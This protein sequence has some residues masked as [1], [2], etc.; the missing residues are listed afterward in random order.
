[1][2]NSVRLHALSAKTHARVTILESAMGNVNHGM[3][4]VYPVQQQVQRH[5]MHRAR[6]R[7]QDRIDCRQQRHAEA[8]TFCALVVLFIFIVLLCCSIDCFALDNNESASQ[9]ALKVITLAS[10]ALPGA[11]AFSVSGAENLSAHGCTLTH[12]QKHMLVGV[13]QLLKET[14]FNSS[15]VDIC[16]YNITLLDIIHG[17]I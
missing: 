8:G 17:H 6:N 10:I 7:F 2:L 16:H 1:M 11:L 14:E 12:Q 15:Q 13:G 9:A 4:F 3:R 5:V